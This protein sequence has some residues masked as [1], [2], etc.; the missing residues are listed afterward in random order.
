MAKRMAWPADDRLGGALLPL[1]RQT[2]MTAA[3]RTGRAIGRAAIRAADQSFWPVPRVRHH[4]I[5][6]TPHIVASILRWHRREKALG[7]GTPDHQKPTARL[8]VD[9]AG[10]FAG[11]ILTK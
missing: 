8:F 3:S 7:T 10:I 6:P 11:D 4:T 5:A 9:R 2:K 1:H